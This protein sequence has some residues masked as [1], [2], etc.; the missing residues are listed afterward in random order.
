[1]FYAESWA[2]VHYLSQTTPERAQR[3]QR[4]LARLRLGHPPAAAFNEVAPREQWPALERELEAYCAQSSFQYATYT[5]DTP[6][7]SVPEQARTL[8]RSEILCRLGEAAERSGD[9]DLRLAEDHYRLAIAADSL[10]AEAVALLGNVIDRRGD[11]IHAESL[12]TAAGELAPRNARVWLL[13]AQGAFRRFQ[14]SSELAHNS[15]S[16]ETSRA[17]FARA[18]QLAPDNLEAM[19]GFG[20]TYRNE[21]SPPRA[22]ASVLLAASARLP[23]RVDVACDLALVLARMDRC[24]EADSI[25]RG[26]V[27][28]LGA[29]SV[30]ESVRRSISRCGQAASNPKAPPLEMGLAVPEAFAAYQSGLRAANQQKYEEAIRHLERADSLAKPG[31]FRDRIRETH[32]SVRVRY[33]LTQAI[34]LINAGEPARAR[35]LLDQ[36]ASEPMDDS[37]RAY[38]DR[39][40]KRTDTRVALQQGVGSAVRGNLQSAGGV[41]DSVLASRA[42]D[43]LKAYARSLGDQVKAHG[44]MEQGMALLRAG[45]LE[46]AR[47]RFAAMKQKPL[48][49]A[50]Q[51]TVENLIRHTDARLAIERALALIRSG[52]VAEARRL[53]TGVMEAPV[54]KNLHAYAEGL[55]KQLDT[56]RPR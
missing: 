35:S 47:A 26:K 14:R 6:F 27:E 22:A 44:E 42:D 7:E 10:D 3:F 50:A 16:L 46:E 48:T 21:P 43:D 19:I 54:G 34:G 31:A 53:L 25:F 23:A 1:V 13:A 20:T 37:T 56:G 8:P 11:R 36:I 32:A 9:K 17:R 51:S 55:L 12:Y 45:R 52:D 41:F 38:V 30:V 18:L 49:P 4:F 28:P 15:Q 29:E 39:L 5:F 33:R 24:A 2:L 40:R